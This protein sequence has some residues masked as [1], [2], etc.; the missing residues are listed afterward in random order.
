MSGRKS[1]CILQ[2]SNDDVVPWLWGP[3]PEV[4]EVSGL[5]GLWLQG[6][7]APWGP[8]MHCETKGCNGKPRG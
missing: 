1:R 8:S 3:R 4:S 2:L 7:K 5:G 6:F